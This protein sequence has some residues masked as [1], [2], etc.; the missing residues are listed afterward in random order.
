MLLENERMGL[1]LYQGYTQ[2]Y[3]RH[4][5]QLVRRMAE[6]ALAR[7][8]IQ[9]FLQPQA[10]FGNGK[11]IGVEALARWRLADGCGP[12]DARTR[13]RRRR[14]S[15]RRRPTITTTTRMKPPPRACLCE[16]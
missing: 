3:W 1:A 7:G 11:I 2:M 4:D 10:E 8:E 9:A 5:F 6:Q 12:F 16:P 14:R 13:R 15:K